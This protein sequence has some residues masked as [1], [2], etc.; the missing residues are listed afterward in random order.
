MACDMIV[1]ADDA[2]F[3][4]PEIR[5][6]SG[7]VSLLMP[8]VLGQKKTNELLFTGDWIDAAE[9]ERLGLVNRVVPRDELE[10]A[11][12]A[13][14]AKIAPTPLPV[15]R[16][17]KLALDAR[18]RG[19]GAAPGRQRQPRPVRDPQRGRDSRA[20][21]VRPHRRRA[22]AEGRAGLARQPLRSVRDARSTAGRSRR[23]SRR[24]S[25]A[26]ASTAYRSSDLR[27]RLVAAAPDLESLH[28]ISEPIEVPADDVAHPAARARAR[29]ARARRGARAAR[30][31]SAARSRPSC[32]PAA[33]PR[34][35]ARRSRRSRPCSRAA[36]LSF[37]D[38]KLA[39]L[40]ALRR[41]R[42][43]DDELRDARRARRGGRGQR[44]AAR[45]A[46]VSLRLAADG[47]LF[48]DDDGAP[49]PHAPG[50]GDL[51][52]ALR[53]LGRARALPRAPAC[54]R[55]SCATSTTSARR[56]T[57]RSSAC[58][59]SS[60]GRSPRSSSSKRPG[61]AGGLP[62]R[63]ADGSLAIAEAFRVP[64]G[65]PHE[66]LPA[67]QHEHALDRPR[68][69]RGACRVHLVRRAQVRRRARGDPVRAPRRRAHVVARRRATCTCRARAPESRFVPG[70]GRG[71]PGG[72]AGADRRASAANGS[73]ST[74]DPG[75]PRGERRVWKRYRSCEAGPRRPRRERSSGL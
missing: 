12:D 5:Y 58:T 46:A 72:R 23:R 47:S 52:D 65:F 53:A 6:G 42:H 25:S 3:G 51:A 55:S 37:L 16:L 61:D 49:S 67:L 63:R 15:L 74:S 17:T 45:A 22:G 4:E 34:A 38:L 54:A 2:R 18:V 35:S 8:F 73:A 24:C 32:W 64:E 29:R 27:A 50:H 39:D 69:A 31:S 30:S 1:A 60:A 13:L 75:I 36:S 56:S 44:R 28:R 71:R 66:Q 10:A 57:P 48:L 21:R 62:V 33:W 20:A 19:D 59:A 70:Q 43:A 26:S 9:A 11:V 40:G 68:R 41:R 14:V 7:P